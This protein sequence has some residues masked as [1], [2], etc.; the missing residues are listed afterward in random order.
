MHVTN[1]PTPPHPRAPTPAE[2]NYLLLPAEPW[3]QLQELLD[4]TWY[5]DCCLEEAMG[6]VFARQVS[7]TKTPAGSQ[8][9]TTACLGWR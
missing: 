1:P 9:A 4:D 6:R 7:R 8:L 2:G 3:W 5:I